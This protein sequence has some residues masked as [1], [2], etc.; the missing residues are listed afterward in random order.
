MEPTGFLLCA[1]LLLV[2]GSAGGPGRA[3]AEEVV[4][5]LFVPGLAGVRPLEGEYLCS[6]HCLMCILVV[7]EPD[8][9]GVLRRKVCM[10]IRSA[11]SASAHLAA[12]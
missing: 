5:C 10:Y 8:D 1:E 2:E 7:V 11:W 12:S 6:C 9:E 3:V 4:D